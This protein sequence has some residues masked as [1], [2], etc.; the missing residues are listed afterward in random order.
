MPG[1]NFE[2]SENGGGPTNFQSFQSSTLANWPGVRGDTLNTLTMVVP[3]PF[4]KVFKVEPWHV[5][6]MRNSENSDHGGATVVSEFSKFSPGPLAGRG[7]TLPTLNR[8]GP[9]PIS[10]FSKCSPGSLAGGKTLKT[11]KTVGHHHVHS[12]QMLALEQSP[13]AKH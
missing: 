5:G 8:V 3:P 7:E 6:R 11:L 2:N 4:S 12:L 10:E 13:G 1:L 9:P